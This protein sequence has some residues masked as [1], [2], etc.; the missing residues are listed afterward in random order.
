MTLTQGSGYDWNYEGTGCAPIVKYTTDQITVI[1]GP[2]P[3]RW[4]V[5]G[6]SFEIQVSETG[7]F[8]FIKN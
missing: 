5:A 7:W 3:F 8:R 2:Y 1:G 4:V 6:T